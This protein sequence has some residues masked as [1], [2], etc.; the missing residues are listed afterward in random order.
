MRILAYVIIA[1][2]LIVLVLFAWFQIEIRAARQKVSADVLTVSLS[3]GITEYAIAGSGADLLVV[4]GS[5]G[6]VDQGLEM[7]GPMADRGYRLIVP[8]RGGYL[9]STLPDGFNAAAQA[10][11]YATLLDH[12]AVERTAVIAISAGVWSALAFAER[13]PERCNALLLLVPAS[14]LAPGQSN[15]GGWIANL[16]LRSDFAAWFA[17]RFA[18]LF[19]ETLSVTLLGTPGD[20]LAAASNSEKARVAS[21]QRLLLPVSMRRPGIEFDIETAANPPKFDWASVDCPILAISTED[22]AFQTASRAAEIVEN[23]R[24]GTL[25]VFPTGGHA[26]V[27]RLDDVLEAGQAFLSKYSVNPDGQE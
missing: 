13:Y 2:L 6:G 20:I 14:Q 16:I 21:M 15:R 24:N 3:H 7:V 27:G 8:S 17:M 1:I 23:A 9:N 5:G 22:D 26:L 19:P 18:E 12:L 10:D 25:I 11:V 4:H